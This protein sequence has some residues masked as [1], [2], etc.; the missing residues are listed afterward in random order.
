MPQPTDAPRDV[1]FGPTGW[2]RGW[3]AM[4]AALW[5][6]PAWA[7]V[8]LFG[9]L[10]N[11]RTWPV[12]LDSLLIPA[13]LTAATTWLHWQRSGPVVVGAYALSWGGRPKLAYRDV[14]GTPVLIEGGWNT[15]RLRL[16]LD[17]GSP[18]AARGRSVDVPVWHLSPAQRAQLRDSVAAAVA[19]WR[20]AAG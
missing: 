8:H 11:W 6:L 12:A 2:Q 13:V 17:P 16:T 10:L 7:V 5:V 3:E 15:A 19:H 4:C 1:Y 14:V 9:A 20:V 18:A